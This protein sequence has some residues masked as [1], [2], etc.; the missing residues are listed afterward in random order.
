[1]FVFYITY[2]VNPES[3]IYL[4]QML[5][6]MQIEPTTNRSLLTRLSIS[7]VKVNLIY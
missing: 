7:Y 3:W 5:D 2:E 4:L 6:H 1:M